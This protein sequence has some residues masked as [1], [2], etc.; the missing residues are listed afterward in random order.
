MLS[1]VNVFGANRA[2]QG[3]ELRGVYPFLLRPYEH[4]EISALSVSLRGVLTDS[5]LSAV[6]V[7]TVNQAEQLGEHAGS[8]LRKTCRPG[9]S[10]RFNISQAV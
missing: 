9:R 8:P 4:M 2:E 10:F 7:I 5:D 3:V 6:N 1:V